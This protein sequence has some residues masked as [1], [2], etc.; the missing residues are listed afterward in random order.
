M[1]EWRR[2]NGKT[3][4]ELAAKVG[5]TQPH[6]SEI[7]NWRNEPSLALAARLSD[8]TGIDMKEFVSEAAQ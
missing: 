8:V 2:Q 1:R 4:S 3:L 5:C 6:L 7:E